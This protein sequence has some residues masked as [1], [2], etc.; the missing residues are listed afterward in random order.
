MNKIH[1]RPP[2]ASESDSGPLTAYRR[3]RITFRPI[4]ALGW[5]FVTFVLAT[6]PLQ[7]A[8]PGQGGSAYFSAAGL[9]GLAVLGA[10]LAADLRR[11]RA[12]TLAGQSVERIEVGLLR[13]R[14]VATGEVQT[15]QGLRRVS[16]A[17]PAVL[18]ASALVLA[19]A[20][21]LLLLASSLGFHLLGATALI[22]AAGIA[23]LG[24][25][26]L[27]PAPGS[28]GSQLVFARA[29]RRSGQRDTAMAAAAR[30]GI[31][32]GWA[33]LAA[34]IALVLFVSIAG[35]WLLLLGGLAIGG[36]RLTLAGAQARQRLAGL[37]ASD[38][39]SAPPPEI[40]SFATAGAA[41]A[42]V[43]LPSRAEVLIVREPDGTFGGI[44][45]VQA[46]A[47]VPGD[48]RESVRV[49]RLTVPADAIAKVSPSEPVV[50]VLDMIAA[51]PATGMAVVIDDGAGSPGEVAGIIT[52]ADLARTI[53]LLNAA[54]PPRRQKI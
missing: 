17:G 40:S 44:V 50:R 3:P 23:A 34:G 11:A 18:V 1:H 47:A 14:V 13:G 6:G 43:A 22:T 35:I 52:P 38:V 36:S 28:P 10:V 46:L 19:A 9:G 21:G 39:M 37:R 15:P 24:V 53:S 33:L 42:D 26:E 32:T 25:A 30:A 51:R 41:F 27:L 54:N 2:T 12:M 45:A 49:R 20:G 16:W 29:W 31:V 48:D 5:L 8:V 4:A 7:L